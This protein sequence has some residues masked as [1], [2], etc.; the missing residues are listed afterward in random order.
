MTEDGRID[1]PSHAIGI[2]LRVLISGT[3]IYLP[4]RIFISETAT[5]RVIEEAQN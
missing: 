1:D 2:F 3:N 4:I 5:I